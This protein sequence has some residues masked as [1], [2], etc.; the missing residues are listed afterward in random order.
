MKS[1]AAHFIVRWEA[2]QC[3]VD[4]RIEED[5]GGWGGVRSLFSRLASS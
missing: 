1:I 5:R 3:D 4:A 2:M